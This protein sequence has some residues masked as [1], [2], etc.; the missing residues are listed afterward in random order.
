[1]RWKAV[2]YEIF[3]IWLSSADSFNLAESYGQHVC[4][5]LLGI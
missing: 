2:V 1:M 4:A 3:G 5:A